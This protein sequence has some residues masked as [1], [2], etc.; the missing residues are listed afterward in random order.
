MR[1]P[2]AVGE[3]VPVGVLEGVCDGVEVRLGVP[4]DV[5]ERVG[6]ND[7]VRVNVPVLDGVP[8]EVCDRVCEPVVVLEGV[9]VGDPERVPVLDGVLVDDRVCEPVWDGVE[10]LVEDRV[11]VREDVRVA[12]GV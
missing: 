6:V 8:V 12:E 7:P 4:L 11:G 10:L 9:P 2:V 5:P 3:R 1:D